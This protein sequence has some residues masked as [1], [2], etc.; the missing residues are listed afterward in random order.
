MPVSFC[1]L[2]CQF[3]LVC[4]FLLECFVSDLTPD[5]G[6]YGTG[7][8]PGLPVNWIELEL[9]SLLTQADYFGHFKPHNEPHKLPVS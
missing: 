8:I 9:D 6:R 2:H 3:L 4:F 5:L 1:L 7:E